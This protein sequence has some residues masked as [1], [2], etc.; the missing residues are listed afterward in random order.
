MEENHIPEE[1]LEIEELPEQETEAI[2]E[3]VIEDAP[4]PETK[5]RSWMW[6]IVAGIIILVMGLTVLFTLLGS[7]VNYSDY[8]KL[9]QYKGLIIPMEEITV[10]ED[11]VQKQIDANLAK[12]LTYAVVDRAAQKDDT[13][14]IDYVGRYAAD[15]SEFAGGS[16]TD[17]DLVLGSGSF[18]DGFEDGLIGASAGDVIDL[19]LTFPE[20][21]QNTLMAGAQVIFTVTV[22]EVKEPV[23]AV[24]NDEFVQANSDVTTVEEYRQLIYDQLL[25]DKQEQAKSDR[26]AKI[27]QT[28]LDNCEISGYP[29]SVLTKETARYRAVYE[30]S[31][32]YYGM[33]LEEFVMAAFSMD[34]TQFEEA[35]HDIAQ[36]ELDIL[37]VSSVIAD[38]EGITV[39]D[40]EYQR[41]VE[42]Y[43]TTNGFTDIEDYEKQTNESFDSLMRDVIR[44]NLLIEKVLAFIEEN[45]LAE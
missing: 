2:E 27:W 10:T 42:V 5:K 1:I 13:V 6:P 37:M 44:N 20:N 8:V 38:T 30:Q 3:T 15:G 34:M 16:A 23:E 26:S 32:N 17:T 9:G 41:E 39:T 7:R 35:I 18:I 25:A 40:E 12:A 45:T 29:E 22:N 11:E 4:I 19:P 21:Y 33:S 24:L 43:L 14:N 31:A 36:S 28:V